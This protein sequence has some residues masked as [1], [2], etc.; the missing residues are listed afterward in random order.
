LAPESRFCN[1]CGAPV[2]APAPASSIEPGPLLPSA[3]VNG[4][5]QVQRF[6]GEGGKKKVYLVY[7]TVLD[8]EV[9]FSLIKTEGLDEVGVER[10]RRE[11][12]VMGRLGGHPHI[13]SVYDM[14]E[15][16][17]QP[18]L[19]T[20]LMG[21]GDLAGLI[22]RTPEHRLPLADALQ[23]VDHVCQALGHAHEHGVIHRDLKPGNVWLSRDG[24][25]KLGDFGL[26]M[27]V[28]KT[29]LSVAGLIVGTVGYMPPEQALGRTPDARSDL[30]S[31][32]AILY[33]LVTGRPPF[34]GDDPVGIIT[35]HV[36]AAPVAPSWHNPLVPIPLEALILRLLAKEPEARPAGA[37][38]V[39]QELAGL[40]LLT[41]TPREGEQRPAAPEANPLDRLAGGVFVGR[42]HELGLV[43]GACDAALAGRAGVVLLAGEPGIGKTTL[44]EETVTYARLRGAQVLWGR[45][46]EWDGAPPYWPWVQIIRGY[47]HTRDPR[48]LRADLGSGAADIAQVVSEVRQRLPDLPELPRMEGEQARFRLF[49]GIATFLRNAT[50]HQP[51]LLVLDDLHWADTPSL[52]LLQFVSRELQGERL[53]IVGT[54]RD[55]EVGRRHP[56]TTTLAELSRGH[57]LQRIPL[58][59]LTTADIT[60]FIALST[61]VEPESAL[62]E[63]VQ[64]E[65][66][67]NP[68]FVSEVVRLLVAEGRLDR[69]RG[70]TTRSVSIPQSVRD[71]VGRRLDRLSAPCNEVLALASVVGR[72]FAL[73]VLERAG[74][75]APAAVLEALEEAV[76]ARLIQE[77]A[78]G[79]RYRFTHALVQETLYAE[80]TAG[81]RLRLHAEVGRALELAHAANPA[82]HYGELAYHFAAAAPVGH[83]AKAVEFAIRAGDRAMS[84]LAWETAIQHY[85][86][87]LYAMD[88]QAEPD[89]AR[90]CDVLLALGL[91]QYRTVLDMSEAPE[92]QQSYLKAAAIAKAIGS[93]ER[94]ARAALEYAGVN[95]IRTPDALLQVQLLEDAL[96]MASEEDS[97]LKAR[98]LARLAVSYQSVSKMAHRVEPMS[99]EALAMARR[100]GDPAVL[101][102]VLVAR[103]VAVWG[104]DNLAERLSVIA[105]ARQ[106][107]EAA[108]DMYY[109]IFSP[110]LE[111][112]SLYEAGDSRALDRTIDRMTAAAQQSRMP[113]FRWSA[114]L[115]QIGR[116]FKEGR[117]AEAEA[118]LASFG[119]ESQSL[120]A[121]YFRT[122]L[123]FVVLRERGRLAEL[124]APLQTVVEMT[125]DH[126]NPFDRHRGQ[127]ARVAHLILLAESGQVDEAR[128]RFAELASRRFAGLERDAYWLATI[129]LLA[130]LCALLQDQQRAA[131]LY[132]LL[133]P[134]ADR[135]AAPASS[136]V[137]LGAVSHYLGL[138]ATVL[139][140]WDDAAR[141][142]D[143]ALAMNASMS[144]VPHEAWTRTSYAGMLMNRR[145]PGDPGR[146]A[147]LLERAQATADEIGMVRLTA[148]VTALREQMASERR[149]GRPDAADRFGLSRRELEVLRLLAD[150]RSNPEIAEALFISVRTVQTHTENIY[151]KLG[152]HARA[153]AVDV[154]H[155]H[156]LL[157]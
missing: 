152:V 61:G 147:D 104:P 23:I 84:Q 54:Y 25:A 123:L 76:Q 26:A 8:R 102:P 120:I 27:A 12:R 92:A 97:A 157:R 18:F 103:Y 22:Q 30:Y 44:A 1:R 121:R 138:L 21:G 149:P 73:P 70:P 48:Q 75:L 55:V 51:L 150:G 127:V 133:L 64:R 4:R 59:G 87:A 93:P 153:E 29:R 33:E 77:E 128:S 83:A 74:E 117:L 15:E 155:R 137:Y 42:E 142:F 14:G 79:G 36:H 6:L 118:S 108:G 34:L 49:D 78:P 135:N 89:E 65:T 91:A 32:G 11:A 100:L 35:Q 106:A 116:A 148:A 69:V 136:A 41:G 94:L 111:L 109:A 17:G 144:A 60:R 71:V 141:H 46:Y 82:P 9:A 146:A 119:G 95:V 68:F 143:A 125:K 45:C 130:D 13:V 115:W 62:V 114:S 105:E 52:L 110:M 80:L 72:E 131:T 63:A 53:L 96:A 56:L 43:R 81:R 2:V 58:H 16:E 3:F 154:A 151:A 126:A 19:V 47:V 86:R 85:E 90:R 28:D 101:A 99:A 140:R 113:Y 57:R 39:R 156:G 37:A 145:S 132:D 38:A 66:E 134:Y 139:R 20:E 122:L 24:I 7:D 5:Y 50:T 129:V 107:A 31:L 40:S 88:L 112:S 10:I 67:G 124:A 98:L